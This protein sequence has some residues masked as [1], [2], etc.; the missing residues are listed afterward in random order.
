[1]LCANGLHTL[2]VECKCSIGLSFQHLGHPHGCRH[3]AW[4]VKNVIGDSSHICFLME[5]ARWRSWPISGSPIQANAPIK[6][7][8]PG[9]YAK[10]FCFWVVRGVRNS[11]EIAVAHIKVLGCEGGLEAPRKRVVFLAQSAF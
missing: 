6:Q 8:G 10:P 11:A 4:A 1:M 5:R 2:I 3:G 9:E 7:T